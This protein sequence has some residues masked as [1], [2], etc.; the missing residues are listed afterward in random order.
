M[1]GYDSAKQKVEVFNPVNKKV[2]ALPDTDFAP[3]ATGL[4][5]C[6]NL[7]CSTND[8]N[9]KC[10][11]WVRYIQDLLSLAKLLHYCPLIS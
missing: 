9:N 1:S 11:N 10:A 2:C 6:G 4:R 3:G 5:M 8:D 7:F